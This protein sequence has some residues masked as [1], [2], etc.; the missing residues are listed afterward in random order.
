[1]AI[2]VRQAVGLD[3]CIGRTN[4]DFTDGLCSGYLTY[5]DQFQGKPLRDWDL[6]NLIVANLNDLTASSLF[7]CGYVVSFVEAIIEDRGL[8]TKG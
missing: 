5:F 6:F 3:K 2:E 4:A 7:N 8:F 1:M